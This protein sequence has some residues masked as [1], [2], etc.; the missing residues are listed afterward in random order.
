MVWAK[1]LVARI[2]AEAGVEYVFG[3]PGGGTMELFDGLHAHQAAVQYVL[4]RHEHGA[5]VMADAYGRATGRPAVVMGQG[6]FIGTN[7]A[8]G[9]AE[10]Y[11]SSSPMVVITD[12]SDFGMAQR[13]ANQNATGEY[14]SPDLLGIL[15]SMTKFTTFAATP[16]ELAIGVQ[17][18]LKHA[19]SGRPGPA[20]V[21]FRSAAVIEECDLETPPFIHPTAG[22]LRSARPV[23]PPAEVERVADLLVD[24][25]RPVVIA[26]NGVHLSNAHDELRE[27]AELLGMPVAT[28]YKGK[29]AVAETHPLALGMSGNY[30]QP[31]ANELIHEAD[32]LLVVGA[33]LAPQ[34]T[35]RE[36]VFDP[37]RQRIVQ[38]DID[39]RNAGWAFP[40]EVGLIG[41]ARE[42][43]AQL[44]AAT[45][46]RVAEHP[47]QAAARQRALAGR[48]SAAGWLQD[49]ALVS[50]ATPI[51]P[52][53]LVRA[54]Q[55]VCDPA[56]LYTLDAGNN[57][58]WMC[59][60]FQPQQAKTLYA[61]GGLAGMGW[62][63][64]AA[65]GLKFAEPDRPVVAVMGDGGFIMSVHALA[66]AVQY[67]LPVVCVVMND[68]SLGMV[69]QH[70]EA[71]QRVIASEFGWVDNARI[72]EAFGAYG[73]RVE[74]ATELADALRSALDAGRPAVVDV[75]IDR[76]TTP[77]R[78]VAP[79]RA[80]T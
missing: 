42:V 65:L 15:R 40:V 45:R 58:V 61:P 28:T 38:V 39:A 51:V 31:L 50:D 44:L 25:E 7:A 72:A 67:D 5:S 37:Q 21:V 74:E 11:M 55:E 29:S 19:V 17:L 41:D 54:L 30:G 26:G 32:V 47:P 2:L 27:L 10:A 33:K 75:V 57:R 52:P 24:A 6:P 35:L 13:P 46:E 69:R 16:K 62:A 9:I 71:R 1:E 64:P 66:T 80:E 48:K 34:D 78:A 4:V 43:L 36:A 60:Y 12:T 59:H 70:Q 49:P 73:V 77:P 23:A 18:A 53:R 79:S 3:I 14:G 20:A 76:H 63:L 56:T 68:S 8:F 22:Y